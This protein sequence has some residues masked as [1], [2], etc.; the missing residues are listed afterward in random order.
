[1]GLFSKKYIA[2]VA[3]SLVLGRKSEELLDLL[4]LAPY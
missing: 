2:C 1:M 4:D 3:G